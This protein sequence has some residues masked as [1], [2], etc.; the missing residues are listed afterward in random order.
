[1]ESTIVNTEQAK[2]LT[3]LSQ[4]IDPE[5]IE[6]HL[7]I[8]QQLYVAPVLG[9]A[10]Y[11]DIV[12]RYD[13]QALTGD[14]GFLYEEYII[15]AVCF[16]AWYSAAPFLNYRTQRAGIQTLASPD[17]V[18]VTPEEFNIYVSR[19]QNLKDF[20][21]QRLNDYLIK[22]KYQ[23]FPLFRSDDTPVESNRGSSLY[24]GFGRRTPK[25]SPCCDDDWMYGR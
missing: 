12:S 18:A 20:Y 2:K 3:S 8:S 5:L 10:L 17:N 15:P 7:L 1:M 22:D 25:K 13:N 21:C 16:G 9:T 24:L 11:D 19:V 4:N 14:S 6:N 23:K